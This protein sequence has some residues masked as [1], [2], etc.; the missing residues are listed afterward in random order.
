MS[1]NLTHEEFLHLL[2]L[3]VEFSKN[4]TLTSIT[5]ERSLAIFDESFSAEE[6]EERRKNFVEH[7]SK[8]F[9]LQVCVNELKMHP[10]IAEVYLRSL[11]CHGVKV[12][13]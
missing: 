8:P 12:Q 3:I 6:R 7:F 10:L 9:S 2:K 1:A 4:K 13:R 5:M 11:E